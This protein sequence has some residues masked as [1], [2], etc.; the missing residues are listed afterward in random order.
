MSDIEPMGPVME[1]TASARREELSPEDL[2][3]ILCLRVPVVVKLAGKKMTVKD[4]T[5]MNI[6]AIIEFSKQAS[7][8]GTDHL[9]HRS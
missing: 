8:F 7:R 6:G 2:R 4:V 9:I 1:Q 3:R 5:A